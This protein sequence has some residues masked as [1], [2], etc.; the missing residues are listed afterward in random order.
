VEAVKMAYAPAK[1]KTGEQIYPGLAPG[2]EAGWSA[3]SVITPDPGIIDV[4]MF[5]YVAHQDPAWDWRQF[6]LDRDAA[7]AVERAGHIA[8]TEPDLQAFK[9]RGGKLLIYHGWNDGG[10]AGGGYVSPQNSIDYYSS[11]QAKMG[12]DQDDWLRLFMI[13][14]MQ[15]C[16]GGP[17]PNQFAVLS[18]MESWREAGV[19]P[20]QMT[21]YRV[22]SNRVVM[23]R[24]L[25]PYPQVAVYRGAGSTDD[26]TNFSCKME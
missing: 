10:N 18:A 15:H 2:G 26:S 19:A 23:T 14:G 11:V 17:G 12:P 6:E 25:C 7:L 4:G 20:D 16:G 3:L 22:I 1:T 13:P 5:R 24:P 8:A 9:A 21:A